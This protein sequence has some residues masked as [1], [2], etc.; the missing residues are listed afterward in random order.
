MP[1]SAP[2]PDGITAVA[3]KERPDTPADRPQPSVALAN[4]GDLSWLACDASRASLPTS[5]QDFP[6]RVRRLI[7]RAGGVSQ[8]A[9]RCGVCERTVRNWRD[10]RSDIPRE[11]CLVLA[12]ALGISPLWLLC[13]EG[14]MTGPTGESA[15]PSVDAT[16]APRAVDA[17][18]L[19]AALQ[20]L[21]S[22]I[23]LAGG[24][25]DL[26]QR[27]EAVAELYSMLAHAGPDSVR[28]LVAFHTTLG[29]HLRSN[30]FRLIT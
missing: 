7:E 3:T 10:G 4:G 19:A 20:V 26:T 17:W 15:L 22:Y 24:S 25:L 16:K 23:A 2:L 1:V 29:G 9:S 28:R 14:E 8:L 18:R 21:Q 27:A 30:R 11:R 6:D 13:G 12:R 5:P